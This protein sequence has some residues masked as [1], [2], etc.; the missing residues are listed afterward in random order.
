MGSPIQILHDHAQLS[1]AAYA[2]LATGMSRRDYEGALID[3][4][5]TE[6]QAAKF[7]DQ[8]SIVSTFSS[9]TGIFCDVVSAEWD[10]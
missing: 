8:Y 7:A 1:D 9:A 10:E 4:A 3:R 6:Q 2:D 5:F